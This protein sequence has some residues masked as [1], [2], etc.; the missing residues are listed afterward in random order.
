M[1]YIN[2]IAFFQFTTVY[3]PKILLNAPA[4]VL[5]QL[6]RTANQ[7]FMIHMGDG[8]TAEIHILKAHISGIKK[9]FSLIFSPIF[10]KSVSAFNK[11]FQ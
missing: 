8:S 2:H 9:D 5:A 6:H 4:Q 1:Y 7:D 11:S 10:S 3:V